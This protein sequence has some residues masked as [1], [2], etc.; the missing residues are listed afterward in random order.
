MFE[1]YVVITS[2]NGGSYGKESGMN[3][4][5]NQR[6]VLA[7]INEIQTDSDLAEIEVERVFKFDEYGNV[8]HYKPELKG[9]S[10]ELV[11]VRK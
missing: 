10:V 5:T 9:F 6:E 7:C 3:L 2:T 11:A 8:T 1:R 4:C